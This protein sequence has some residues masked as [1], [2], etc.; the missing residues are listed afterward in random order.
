MLTIIRAKAG[1]GSR[2]DCVKN[3]AELAGININDGSAATGASTWTIQLI[4][5]DSGEPNFVTLDRDSTTDPDGT[6]VFAAYGGPAGKDRWLR[7]DDALT[8]AQ[9]ASSWPHVN[10]DVL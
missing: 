4:F 5:P 2:L 1:T 10:P 8:D 9:N 7:D 6:D 3:G